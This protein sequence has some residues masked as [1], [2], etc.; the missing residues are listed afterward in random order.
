VSGGGGVKSRPWTAVM[1]L[2]IKKSPKNRQKIAKK[3]PK[4]GVS[5][6]MRL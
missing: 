4:I 5:V 6:R 3:S 2:R 1:I